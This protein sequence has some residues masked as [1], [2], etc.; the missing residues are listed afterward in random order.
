MNS[1]TDDDDDDG[2]DLFD[3]G[4]STS[5]VRRQVHGDGNE[6]HHRNRRTVLSSETTN[7][8]N[9]V[10]IRRHHSH[11]KNILMVRMASGYAVLLLMVSL[12]TTVTIHESFG[13]TGGHERRFGPKAWSMEQN[14]VKG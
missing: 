14:V 7:T 6:S 5:R 3:A 8:E 2:G 4:A 13:D 10:W 1:I 12:P 9:G 11:G